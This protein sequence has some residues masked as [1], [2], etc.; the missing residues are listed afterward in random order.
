MELGITRIVTSGLVMQLL[1]GS[2]IIEVDNSVR[3]DRALLLAKVEFGFGSGGKSKWPTSR[4]VPIII[5]RGHVILAN[6]VR[7]DSKNIEAIVQ[8][9]APRNVSEI[10]NFLGLTGY[11]RRFVNGFSKIALLMTK[12]LHKNVQFIWSN[13]CQESFEKLK[14]MLTEVS[15]LT[16][17]ESGKD[18]VIYNDAH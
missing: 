3:E 14:Q 11:Y 4:L 17:L 13:E 15:V 7:V 12:Q 10:R 8:W 5:F 1:A 9:K 2:K 18:F 16:L 6:G